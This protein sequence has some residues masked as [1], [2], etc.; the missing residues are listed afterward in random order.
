M[1]AFEILGLN[2]TATTEEIKAAYRSKCREHHPDHG[3]EADAMATVNLAYEK[4]CDPVA[5]GE[6]L[7]AD[8]PDITGKATISFEDR[9]AAFLRLMAVNWSTSFVSCSFREYL[10]QSLGP[11]RN[12]LKSQIR[13]T[14][15]SLERMRDSGDLE[16]FPQIADVLQQ[17]SITQQERLAKLQDDLAVVEYFTGIVPSTSSDFTGWRELYVETM[18]PGGPMENAGDYDD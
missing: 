4:I 10:K 8:C 7:A 14:E 11:A 5:R 3:G 15:E 6:Y 17:L 13:K 12:T 9:C 18:Q 16:A 1:N 2:L